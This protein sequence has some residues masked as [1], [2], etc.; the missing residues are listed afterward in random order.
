M[1][2][3]ELASI[4]SEIRFL[5]VELMKIAAK[6]NLSFEAVLEEFVSNAYQVKKSLSSEKPAKAQ[7]N[8]AQSIQQKDVSRAK[9]RL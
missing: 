5:T 7:K 2:L 1:D 3:E 8:F 4:N 6:R 9:T